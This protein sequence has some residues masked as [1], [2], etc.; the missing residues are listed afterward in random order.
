M[1]EQTPPG[2]ADTPTRTRSASPSCASAA[3]RACAGWRSARSLLAGVL[4]LLLAGFVYWLLTT[5][6]GRDLLLAQ[7]V[8]RLPENATL[9][10]RSVD[11]PLSGPLT[12][13]GVRFT[14][15]RIVFTAD[16][17][18]LDPAIRPLLGRRL[19]LDALQIANATL[20]LPKSDEPFELPRWPEVLPE[21]APPLELQAD[22]VRVDGFLLTAGRREADRHPHPAHRPGCAAGQAARRTPVPRQRPRPLQPARRLR[23]A[24]GLPHRPH[25]ERACSP[26]PTGARRRASAWSRAATCRAWTSPSPGTCRRRCTPAWCCAAQDAPR[27][28]VVR[29]CRRP[30][31]GP[32]HR[33]R[34]ERGRPA[35]VRSFSA[36]GVGGSANLRGEL[37]P[38]RS[39]RHRAAVE[40]APG[41]PG[42]RRAAARA[43]RVRRHA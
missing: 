32:A 11:G 39:R 21:I 40:G 22:D 43:A 20:E 8:A 6:G 34:D 10:W 13:H 2:P 27:W 5:V 37:A 31:P 3:A 9:S 17:V 19:R 35:A 36:D 28:H 30:R 1:S 4:T 23:A 14:Y 25:R 12:M 29:G 7:I 33:R 18:H 38:G 42:A 24:R 26:P 16:R 41:E 15:D